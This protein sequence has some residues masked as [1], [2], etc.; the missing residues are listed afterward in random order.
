[1]EGELG[2]TTADALARA[3]DTLD[4]ELLWRRVDSYYA[5]NPVLS[6]DD[7]DWINEVQMLR[8]KIWRAGGG[9]VEAPA[10]S[11]PR[12]HRSVGHGSG[13]MLLTILLDL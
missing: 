13:S 4:K 5:Q 2:L 3:I 9:G 1:L 12:R 6:H 11:P 7:A 8:G 10:D